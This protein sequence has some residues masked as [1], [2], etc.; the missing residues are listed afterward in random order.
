MT[1]R[2]DSLLFRGFECWEA[3]G[4]V[5]ARLLSGNGKLDE[6]SI[7]ILIDGEGNATCE[8]NLPDDMFVGDYS[9]G[10][11]GKIA[12]KYMITPLPYKATEYPKNDIKLA[13]YMVH[14]SGKTWAISS[15]GEICFFM[16][17]QTDYRLVV[18]KYESTK[19]IDKRVKEKLLK[20]YTPVNSISVYKSSR[21]FV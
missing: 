19:T 9:H 1:K 4:K 10:M 15:C 11:L 13:A 20:G 14:S 16:N 5:I 2:I 17:K 7:A 6:S 3:D 8:V 21:V 18:S 12:D